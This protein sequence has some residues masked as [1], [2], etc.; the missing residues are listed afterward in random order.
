MTTCLGA[1]TTS[2]R[3]SWLLLDFPIKIS[4]FQEFGITDAA[5]NIG[6]EVLDIEPEE[7][8]P[9]GMKD[10]HVVALSEEPQVPQ[11]QGSRLYPDLSSLM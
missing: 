4:P 5:K 8:L 11:N 10:P 7:K 6:L 1:T 2:S 3:V 9:E